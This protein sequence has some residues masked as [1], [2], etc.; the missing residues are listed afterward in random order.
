M[1]F[2]NNFRIV[3]DEVT[4]PSPQMKNRSTRKAVGVRGI[5]APFFA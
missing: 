5:P 3:A 4:S 1:V 2:D